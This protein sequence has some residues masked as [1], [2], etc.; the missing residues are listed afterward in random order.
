MGDVLVGLAVFGFFA[1]VIGL[2][3]W[4]GTRIRRRSRGGVD[5][6]VGPLQEIWH[7][8]AYRARL[9]AETVEQR[10]APNSSP[11]PGR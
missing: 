9:E 7:P 10:M 6:V 11:D 1:A 2:L 3:V 5:A 8:T 4:Q